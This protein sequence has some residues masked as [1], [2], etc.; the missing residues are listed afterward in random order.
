MKEK[1]DNLVFIKIKNFY[2]AKD[3]VKQMRKQAIDW[4][5]IFAKDTLIK[6]CYS[7]CIKNT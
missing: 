3:D 1:T 2:S 7:K 4:E 6:D 5:K